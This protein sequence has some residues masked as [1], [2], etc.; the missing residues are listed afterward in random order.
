MAASAP[1]IYTA[2]VDYVRKLNEKVYVARFLLPQ[3]APFSFTA[4]QYCS[5]IIEQKI[6]RSLSITSVP[7]D[8]GYIDVCAD[9]TPMGPASQ[10]LLK[11][12]PG[13]QIR[14]LGPLGRFVVDRES[15]REKVFLATG[16]G[17]APF[18]SMITDALE[19]GWKGNMRLIWG[20]RYEEDIF[21]NEDFAHLAAQHVNFSYTMTL[22]RPTEIWKGEKGRVTAHLFG[23]DNFLQKEYYLCGSR[24]M[25]DGVKMA[26]LEKNIPENQIKTE[27]FY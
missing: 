9:I 11:L 5:F 27:L 22:S 13:E 15:P 12:A 1:A 2:T 4:G 17:I 7:A 24:G 16:T 23:E 3:G 10:W 20:Q 14:F 21:W 26:L 19:G 8:T 18:R 6:R 25:V